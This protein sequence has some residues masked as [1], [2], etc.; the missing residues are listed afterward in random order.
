[1]TRS[2]AD[3]N[4]PDEFTS[5]LRAARANRSQPGQRRVV[6]I[7]FCDVTG[8]TALAS[9]L[10]PEDWAEIM[11]DAF[12]FLIAPVQRYG[13]TIARLMGDAILAF[14]GAPTSHEDDP[15]RAVLAALAILDDI[16]H[17]RAQIEREYGLKFDVRA[18]I[19]TG[20]VVVGEI[21]SEIA[22]EYTAM[23]DAINLAA[24]MEQTADP[25]TVR[26]SENTYRL[27]APLFNCEPLGEISLKGKQK[28]VRA[29]RVLG[30]RAEPGR[31]RGIQ[32]L[33]SPVIGRRREMDSLREALLAVRQGRGQIVCLIGEA[34]LGKSRLIEELRLQ[35]Q[36][37]TTDQPPWV[38]SRGISYDAHRPYGV[39]QQFLRQ[40]CDVHE[41]DSPA[42]VRQKITRNVQDL[43]ADQ[44]KHVIQAS[45]ALLAVEA[46][47]DQPK[48]TGEAFKHELFDAWENMVRGFA[49]QAPFVVVIDDLH[50]ADSA[51]VELLV[52]LLQLTNEVPILFLCAF[53]PFRRAPGWQVKQVADT[54]YPHRYREITLSPLSTDDSLSLVTNLLAIS[55]LPDELQ[56]AILAKTDGNPFFVEEVIRM[57]ID[58]G[59][60]ARDDSGARWQ[61]VATLADTEI[62]DNLQALLSSRIDRLE[63]EVRRTLQLAAVIGRSFYFRVLNVISEAVDQLDGHLNTLQRIDMIH[64]KARLPE[65][66]YIFRHALTRDAAYRSIV[67]R[68]RRQFHRKVGEALEALFPQRLEEEASRLAHH[69]YEARDHPRALKYDM[70]AGDAA[71]RLFANTEAVAHYDRAI[72][73]LRDTPK[74]PALGGNGQQEKNILKHLYTRRGRALE[75]MGQYDDAINN[76]QELERLAREREDRD[77]ELSALIPMATIQAT[78][79]AKFNPE[80]AQALSD[81]ALAMA[82]ELE[83]HPAEAKVL[84][85]LMLLTAFTEGDPRQAAAYGEQSLAI[86]RRYGLREELAYALHDLSRP[87]TSIGKF[88]QARA[89]LEEAQDLWRELGNLPMLAD[90][91]STLASGHLYAGEFDKALDKAQQAQR[92]SQSIHSLWGQAYSLG[93]AAPI[94][95]ERGEMGKAIEAWRSTMPLAEQANFA[96][97]PVYA[98][99]HLA[100]LYAEIGDLDQAFDLIRSAISASDTGQ[101]MLQGYARMVLAKL[102]LEA[103][104]PAEAYSTLEAALQRREREQMDEIDVALPFTIEANILLANRA[105]ERVLTLAEDLMARNQRRSL[106]HVGPYL[107][108]YS[109][110]ALK[111]LGREE[112]AYRSVK[113]AREVAE[114]IGSRRALWQILPELSRMEADLGNQEEADSLRQQLRAIIDFIAEH[115]GSAELKACFLDLPSVR[116]I[117]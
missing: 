23:G 114:R 55:D 36:G 99:L 9:Q 34:G 84:W 63:E 33:E 2:S 117:V 98:R 7:L 47:S 67:R 16:R 43:P 58:R 28:A 86:A 18:G 22:R 32:G 74:L 62:P 79:T 75:E 95:F 14:F 20:P 19:N 49:A 27:V 11:D 45:E 80:Q 68:Q 85:N 110:L 100:F 8:S 111:G 91:L 48:L 50:W 78:F 13:G 6:T 89:M 5:K 94:Y 4:L 90:N 112:E 113:S 65:L 15:Q 38:E 70:L 21:G 35:W 1:M 92:I 57:L 109:G 40:V 83:N 37:Q 101:E 107:H 10:D 53:R 103:G 39:F 72:E 46:E 116:E 93:I 42:V 54:E 56:Q 64:E 105:F 60:I 77:L 87:Y 108:L 115:A 96:G 97:L 17:F 81:R 66:E 31:L 59:V 3:P 104:S 71:A 25:G 102:Q 76:Y 88:D 12:D 61:A 51:S 73:I 82:Q 69:F 24:R 44:Q 26:I 52:H 106:R 29:Y 30:R 41:D